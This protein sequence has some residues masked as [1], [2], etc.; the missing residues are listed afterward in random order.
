MNLEDARKLGLELFEKGHTPWIAECGGGY[1]I[2]LLYKGQII[3][4]KSVEEFT[5]RNYS[6]KK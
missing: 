4:V 3:K 1:V 6:Q 5:A 2:R